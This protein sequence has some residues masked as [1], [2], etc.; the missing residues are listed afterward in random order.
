MIITRF[1][2]IVGPRQ[3]G[4]YGMVLPNFVRAALAK[5]PIRV[6]GDGLQTRNFTYISDCVEALVRL[7]ETPAAQGQIVNVGGPLEI[8]I[9]DLAQRVK[10]LAHSPSP[11]VLVPY[12]EAYPEGT[13]EDMR[14]RVPCICKIQALTSWT[15]LTHIDE[16]I[17][18][19]IRYHRNGWSKRPSRWPVLEP[20]AEAIR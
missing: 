4:R 7:L 5:E 3:S 8:S 20:A 2:N 14:R 16:M 12:N 19:V 6:F 15:P 18:A 1:F 17:R 11:V 13:Y 9:Y 10:R